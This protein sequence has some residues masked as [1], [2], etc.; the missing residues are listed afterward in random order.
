[1]TEV[2]LS[3][4]V[5]FPFSLITLYIE[6]EVHSNG[7]FNLCHFPLQGRSVSTVLWS[8]Q[9]LSLPG[10]RTIRALRAER[11]ILTSA[12]GTSCS[13][14]HELRLFA[15]SLLFSG[16]RATHKCLAFCNFC[17]NFGQCH[18]PSW[19]TP[20]LLCL[21]K[22]RVFPLLP[23]ALASVSFGFVLVRVRV[24]FITT[25]ASTHL[26]WIGLRILVNVSL[27]AFYYSISYRRYMALF[28]NI[29]LSCAVY[30]ELWAPF[31]TSVLTASSLTSSLES[32]TASMESK[33]APGCFQF[34]FL[35]SIAHINRV[36]ERCP[37]YSRTSLHCT[38][39]GKQPVFAW[40]SWISAPNLAFECS[41]FKFKIALVKVDAT[42]MRWPFWIQIS[43][44][45]SG[46]G[47]R[48]IFARRFFARKLEK[49]VNEDA[50]TSTE[51]TLE[52]NQ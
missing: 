29:S 43:L 10:D 11:K 12:N 32:K 48:P 4:V 19:I 41:L 16:V 24:L 1:V 3:I 22:A 2:E 5:Y 21:R 13:A 23:T 18:S 9:C 39:V 36:L 47:G 34:H 33:E 50:K 49:I 15:L 20:H 42:N 51:K 7:K 17:E 8:P 28:T 31:S 38:S 46:D 37:F 44:H 30:V 35:I 14:S 25:C 6:R 40:N 27:H 26:S 52:E 45:S